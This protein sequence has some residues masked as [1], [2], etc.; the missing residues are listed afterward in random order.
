[1]L[2]PFPATFSR[3][4]TEAEARALLLSAFKAYRQVEL[5]Q[6]D[7]EAGAEALARDEVSYFDPR[8]LMVSDAAAS[9]AFADEHD[10]AC[11]AAGLPIVFVDVGA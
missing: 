6:A 1:M 4:F 2:T 7:D 9:G 8:A 3:V 5:E 11:W 10:R